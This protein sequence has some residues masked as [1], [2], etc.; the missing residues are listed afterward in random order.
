MTKNNVTQDEL[1]ILEKFK[2]TPEREHD[3]YIINADRF[4]NQLD[5]T[6]HMTVELDKEGHYTIIAID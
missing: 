4:G 3:S 1:N 2:K 6:K 5:E